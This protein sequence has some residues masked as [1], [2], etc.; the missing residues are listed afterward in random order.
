MILW[1]RGLLDLANVRCLLDNSTNIV[2]RQGVIYL[3]SVTHSKSE[4]AVISRII[5]LLIQ[6]EKEQKDLTDYLGLHRNNFTEWKRGGKRSYMYYIDEIARFFDVS[7]TFL[8]RGCDDLPEDCS[9]LIRK[10]RLM[11]AEQKGRLLD[12]AEAL[13]HDKNDNSIMT[14]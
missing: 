7:P 5:E 3:T 9:E 4:P 10:F 6:Q 13:L 8:L 12:Q 11:N 1:L 2:C 14:S